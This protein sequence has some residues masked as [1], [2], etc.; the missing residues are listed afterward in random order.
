MFGF[1]WSLTCVFI[2]IYWT[3]TL[4]PKCPTK[5]VYIMLHKRDWNPKQQTM[6]INSNK[7]CPIIFKIKEST[8][9]LLFDPILKNMVPIVLLCQYGRSYNV[10]CR[11]TPCCF[12]KSPIPPSLLPTLLQVWYSCTQLNCFYAV[13]TLGL[14]CVSNYPIKL[15]FVPSH[16]YEWPIGNH[17]CVCV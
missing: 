5:L 15:S 13:T 6:C 17:L 7:S 4:G 11:F 2:L 10:D 1:D 16:L 9:C 8:I 12:E 3:K 14:M